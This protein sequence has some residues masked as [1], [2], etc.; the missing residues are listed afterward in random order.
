M[1]ADKGP[2]AGDMLVGIFFILC[3]LCLALVGGGCTIF[4]LTAIFDGSD[5]LTGI[6]IPL[7]LV[8]LAAL[9]A[10]AVLL[11]AGGKVTFG[12]M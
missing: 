5:G 2:S 9:A 6:G 7:L 11:W 4:W 1:S 10:G 12:K 8:S 3:G